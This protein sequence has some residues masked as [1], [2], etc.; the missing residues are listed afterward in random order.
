MIAVT[1][2]LPP[3]PEAHGALLGNDEPQPLRFGET[4]TFKTRMER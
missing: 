1:Q 4:G 3:E 2:N